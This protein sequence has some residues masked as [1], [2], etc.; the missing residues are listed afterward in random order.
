M[1][2]K[3]IIVGSGPAGYTA[4]IY[5]ARAMLEPVMISGVQPAGSSPTPPTSRTIRASPTSSRAPGSWSRC[6][7]RRSMSARGSSPTTSSSV[8]LRGGR[9]ASSATSATTYTADAADPGD[10]RPGA[11][12][13]N[14]PSEQRF[15]G[16]GVSACATCDG[17]F[18]S[19][20]E[21][22]VVGGGNTAVEDALFL[23]HFATKVTVVHRRDRS[24]RRE[25]PAEPAVL[26]IT[27]SPSSGTA[28]SRTWAAAAGP[29]AVGYRRPPPQRQDRRDQRAPRRRRVRRH[30]PR[31]V[32]RS[33]RQ[34][35]PHEAVRLHLDRAELDR[36][37]HS[38]R[39][40]CRRRDRRGLPP[41]RD[42]GRP[43][44]A[45]RRSRRRSS[46][47]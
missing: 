5:A 20:R 3:V 13:L 28:S 29:A 16:F 34:P 23:T 9:S 36:D 39:L 4:A 10:R 6:G 45:W 27:R 32:G 25:D 14:L 44:A 15:Q 40:R 19:N 47:R 7:R 31:S 37:Q 24:P 2:A 18:Y 38:R 8:D 17:F 35:A 46:S 21:V 41:G 43:W 12:W 30:R 33:R 42:R 11:S 26:P 22:V 1:H